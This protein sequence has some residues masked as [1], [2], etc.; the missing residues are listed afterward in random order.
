MNVLEILMGLSV[1]QGL[2]FLVPAPL[3]FVGL[4]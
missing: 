1:R 3:L 2:T 4:N